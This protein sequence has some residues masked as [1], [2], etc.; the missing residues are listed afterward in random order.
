[1]SAQENKVIARYYMGQIFNQKNLAAVDEFFS[2]EVAMHCKLPGVKGLE[3]YR[4]MVSLFVRAF[5]DLHLSYQTVIC[6]GEWVSGRFVFTGTHEADFAGI[7]ATGKH[8]CVSGISLLRFREGRV[9]EH[10]TEL[11][12]LGLLQQLGVIMNHSLGVR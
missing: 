6:E 12:R 2:P 11:D 3:G 5:P 10:W 1:M 7:P 4:R 8:I 9:I